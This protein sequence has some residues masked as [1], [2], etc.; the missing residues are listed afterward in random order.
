ML[1]AKDHF[2]IEK[3]GTVEAKGKSNG[4]P[5]YKVAGKIHADGTR[6]I[7]STQYSHY[8]AEKSEKIKTVA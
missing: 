2:I 1:I 3:A 8:K 7:I 6:E 4:V 5:L